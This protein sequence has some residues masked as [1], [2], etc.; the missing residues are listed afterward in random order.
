M[1]TLHVKPIQQ[2]VYEELT[3]HEAKIASVDYSTHRHSD[4]VLDNQANYLPQQHPLLNAPQFSGVTDP[5][6]SPQATRVTES[7]QTTEKAQQLQQQP[8]LSYQQQL[9]QNTRY[10]STPSLTR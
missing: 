3:D 10:V 2:A 9:E 5:L 7:E 4:P 6:E 8:Q 1:T